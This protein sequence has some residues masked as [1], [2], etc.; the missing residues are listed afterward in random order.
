MSAKS[1]LIAVFQDVADATNNNA[2]RIAFGALGAHLNNLINEIKPTGQAWSNSDTGTWPMAL[3]TIA[4]HIHGVR[5]VLTSGDLLS[6]D[7]IVEFENNGISLTLP[8]ASEDF[9]G[10]YIV[11]AVGTTGTT[12]SWTVDGAS[13]SL[14]VA[15]YDVLRVYCNGSEWLPW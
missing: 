4:N 6:S 3:E 14:P 12:V 1:R 11:K 15:D 7:A 2:A 9:H 13:G 10:R 5:V 8:A